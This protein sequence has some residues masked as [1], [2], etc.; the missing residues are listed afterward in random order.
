MMTQL[1]DNQL[2]DWIAAAEADDLPA[3][4]SVAAGLRRDLAPAGLR[5]LGW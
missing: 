2:P 1:R 4:R 3:L 5:D